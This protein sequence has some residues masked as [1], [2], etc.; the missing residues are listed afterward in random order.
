MLLPSIP[1]SLFQ[2]LN[3]LLMIQV[4]TS[5]SQTSRNMPWLASYPETIAKDV[6][7]RM[8]NRRGDRTQFDD[9]DAFEK[10]N[11]SSLGYVLSRN[12]S[13]PKSMAIFNHGLPRTTDNP[14]HMPRL[15]GKLRKEQTGAPI[16]LLLVPHQ[17]TVKAVATTKN[18]NKR[19]H[20]QPGGGAQGGGRDDDDDDDD[21][22]NNGKKKRPSP[23]DDAD[24]SDTSSDD[25]DDNPQTD[26][27]TPPQNQPTQN[28]IAQGPKNQRPKLQ[29]AQSDTTSGLPHPLRPSHLPLNQHHP[30]HTLLKTLN[31]PNLHPKTP[32][33]PAP[34]QPL[35]DLP[36]SPLPRPSRS[37]PRP[38]L[39]LLLLLLPLP[40]HPLA[41]PT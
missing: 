32:P 39:L 8:K 19:R 26:P 41:T 24:T 30:Q 40:T 36:L 5:S 11:G 27:K 15:V 2:L 38:P 29:T 16:E 9:P 23:P 1:Y 17:T 20:A 7:T 12:G 13:T 6:A 10:A 28:P 35:T 25:E 33:P 37:H 21:D 22:R 3:L 31:L 4:D 14:S 34:R 18:N